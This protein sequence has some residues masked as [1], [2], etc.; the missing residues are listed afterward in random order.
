MRGP[1]GGYELAR[2][3][4][5]ITAGDIVRAAMA[6]TGEDAMPVAP[7]SALVDQVVAPMVK[8]AGLSFLKSLDEVTI[9][10]LCRQAESAEGAPGKGDVDFAI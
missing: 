5:R 2:E 6:S 1:R 7:E 4:R 9:D 8:L 3:R 10:D